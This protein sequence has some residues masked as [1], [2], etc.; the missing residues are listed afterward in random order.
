MECLFDLWLS[1]R[2]YFILFLLFDEQLVVKLE[3]YVKALI[4][5]AVHNLS[6]GNWNVRSKSGIECIISQLA[7]QIIYAFSVVV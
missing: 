5:N 7:L 4:A 2:F 1:I 6:L 3:I